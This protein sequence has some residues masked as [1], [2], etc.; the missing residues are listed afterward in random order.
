MVPTR[1]LTALDGSEGWEHRMK[2]KEAP[3]GDILAPQAEMPYVSYFASSDV[4]EFR[5]QFGKFPI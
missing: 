3:A 5:Q 4:L 1:A 2:E